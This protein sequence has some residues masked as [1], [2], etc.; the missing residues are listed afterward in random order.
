MVAAVLVSQAT[1]SDSLTMATMIAIF[2]TGILW[3]CRWE[4]RTRPGVAAVRVGRP[5][6]NAGSEPASS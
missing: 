1:G 6:P 2:A 5:P 4:V 3:F